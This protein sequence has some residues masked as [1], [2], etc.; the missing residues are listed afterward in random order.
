MDVIVC[1]N[2]TVRNERTLALD[3]VKIGRAHV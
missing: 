2:L 3:D 1:R